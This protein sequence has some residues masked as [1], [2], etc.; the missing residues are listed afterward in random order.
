MEDPFLLPP[1]VEAIRNGLL[2]GL[3]V[4]DGFLYGAPWLV[5]LVS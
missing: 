2:I 3:S 5:S 4:L 1:T